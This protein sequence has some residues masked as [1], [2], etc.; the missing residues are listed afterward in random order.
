VKAVVI[1]LA[2]LLAVS[3]PAATAAFLVTGL[4]VCAASVWLAWRGARFRSCPHMRILA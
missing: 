3:H 1:V 2:F 4:A